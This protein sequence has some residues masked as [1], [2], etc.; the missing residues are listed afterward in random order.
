[1]RL[2]LE[3]LEKWDKALRTQYQLCNTVIM[4]RNSQDAPT[5][6]QLSAIREAYLHI[7]DL[8]FLCICAYKTEKI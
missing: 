1:M 7:S 5:I 6:E 4:P 3:T 8:V 2:D